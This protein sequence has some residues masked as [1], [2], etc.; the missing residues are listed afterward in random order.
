[1]HMSLDYDNSDES[2]EKLKEDIVY[3]VEAAQYLLGT[4]N[5]L[6]YVSLLATT[7]AMLAL[8]SRTSYLGLAFSIIGLISGMAGRKL[9]KL[10][11]YQ[12]WEANQRMH[13]MRTVLSLHD[14]LEGLK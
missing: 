12:L 4:S 13:I 11:K 5:S 2:I 7:I 6:Q 9:T 14:P 1:M 8:I 10:S 3:Y